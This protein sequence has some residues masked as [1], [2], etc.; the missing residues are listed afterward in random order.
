MTEFSDSGTRAASER[1]DSDRAESRRDRQGREE[2]TLAGL[3]ADHVIPRLLM[4]CREAASEPTPGAAHVETLARLALS[5]DPGAAA[6]HVAAIRDSGASLQTILNDLIGPA[7]SRLGEYWHHDT[8]DFAEVAIGA[9]RLVQVARALGLESERSLP[10]EAPRALFASPEAERHGL[11][12]QIVSQFF[13]AEGWRVTSAPGSA[14]DAIVRI[15]A[16]ERFDFIGLSVGSERASG[17][18]GDLI[19]R[20]RATSDA[21]IGLGGPLFAQDPERA[22]ALGADF[23]AGDAREAVEKARAHLSRRDRRHIN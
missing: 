14:A 13:R 22:R 2:S 16:S 10:P 4:S 3:V 23:A 11:G 17:D 18:L 6:A 5:R 7:A 1:K 21:A 9:S 19:G 8:A 15:A 12:A 20:L